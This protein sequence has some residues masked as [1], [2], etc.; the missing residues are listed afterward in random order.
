MD[1]GRPVNGCLL[2]SKRLQ[3]QLGLLYPAK[4]FMIIENN[5]FLGQKQTS[6]QSPT[7]AIA[8]QMYKSLAIYLNFALTLRS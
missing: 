5:T 3:Y 6:E 1:V 7:P 8:A 2:S 4:L